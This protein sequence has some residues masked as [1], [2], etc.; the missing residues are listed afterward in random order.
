MRYTALKWTPLLLASLSISQNANAQVILGQ[1]KAPIQAEHKLSVATSEEKKYSSMSKMGTLSNELKGSWYLGVDVGAAY[2]N[3]PDY[4]TVDNGSEFPFPEHLDQ[5]S[6]RLKNMTQ[7]GL[8][9]GY[10]WKRNERWMPACS[11]GLRYQHLFKKNT[12]GSIMQYSLPDFKNYSYRWGISADVLSLY[13]KVNLATFG[14]V[15]PYVD[16]GIGVSFNH[17][18]HY[19]ETAYPDITPRISPNFRTNTL[20]QLSYNV[21]LGLDILL[22]QQLLLYVGYDFQSFGRMQSDNGVS[23]WNTERLSLGTFKTNTG[24]IGLTYILDGSA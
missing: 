21:G 22:T 1:Q 2:T 4:M 11:L 10:R 13:S 20:H 6:L 18:R 7:L 19:S 17:G 15:M 24:L 23:T 9:A 12:E 14:R 16:A 5:Y 8:Q 3:T